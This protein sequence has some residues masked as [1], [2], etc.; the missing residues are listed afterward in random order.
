MMDPLDDRVIGRLQKRVAEAATQ[1]LD[2]PLKVGFFDCTTLY[3]ESAEED[4]LRPFGYRKDGKAGD[5]PGLLAL[6]V[7]RDGLPVAYEV[8]PGPPGKA[9]PWVRC[10]S[11]CAR[12]RTRSVLA[13]PPR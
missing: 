1:L 5:V 13:R 6:G 12:S 11:G 10:G 2:P 3:F 8:F 4:A 7:T 9:R